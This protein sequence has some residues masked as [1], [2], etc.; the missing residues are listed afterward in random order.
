[1]DKISNAV[2]SFTEEEYSF[3]LTNVIK[4]MCFRDFDSSK[5]DISKGRLYWNVYIDTTILSFGG[6]MVD[7]VAIAIHSALRTTR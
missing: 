6:N 4:D 5:L 2:P 1:M 7:W 3:Y